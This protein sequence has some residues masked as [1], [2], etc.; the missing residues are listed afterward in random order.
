MSATLAELLARYGYIFVA[1]FM[2]V[3][4]IGIP[5]PGES[6]L[7]TAAAVAGSGAL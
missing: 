1:L 5:I 2:F 7:I 4:S 6:D 3:E